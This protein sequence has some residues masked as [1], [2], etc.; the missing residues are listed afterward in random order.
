[1][2]LVDVEALS[3]VVK[4]EV[5]YDPISLSNEGSY[6]LILLGR[7]EVRLLSLFGWR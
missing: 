6:G 3:G 5:S 1:M 2:K 7:K 4:A